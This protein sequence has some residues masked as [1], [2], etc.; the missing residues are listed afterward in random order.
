[1]TGSGHLRNGPDRSPFTE[2]SSPYATYGRGFR[3]AGAERR[4][5]RCAGAA[6]VRKADRAIIYSLQTSECQLVRSERGPDFS[7]L[8]RRQ[9]A[10]PLTI[11]YRGS[12]GPLNLVIDS[13]GSKLEGEGAWG[14]RPF[15]TEMIPRIVS[16]TPLTPQARWSQTARLAKDPPRDRQGNA[17]GSGRRVHQQWHRRRPHAVGTAR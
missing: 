6:K 1:M 12:K 17:G 2:L 16:G 11:Q 9:K 14:L 13:T 4:R 5:F 8:S 15:R 10:L 7:T 3:A